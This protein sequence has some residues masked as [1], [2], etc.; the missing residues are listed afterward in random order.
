MELT[1]DPRLQQRIQ[2]EVELGRYTSPSEVIAHALDLL[3]AEE[4]WISGNAQSI[5]DH[6]EESFAAAAAG[7]TYTPEQARAI[8]AEHRAP[9]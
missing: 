2:R 1:L 3:Q 7:E 5:R 6:I 9:R 4:T 8:L